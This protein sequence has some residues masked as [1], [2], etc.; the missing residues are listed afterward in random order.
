M[1]NVK[2]ATVTIC[3]RC[4]SNVGKTVVSTVKAETAEKLSKAHPE[5]FFAYENK[6]LKT[7][8]RSLTY[9]S[10]CTQC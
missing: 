1:N 4:E 8:Y 10:R 2:V 5:D 3:E 9:V 7:S 6:Q